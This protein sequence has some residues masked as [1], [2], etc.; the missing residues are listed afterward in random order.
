MKL[1]TYKEYLKM[2]KE[3]IEETLAPIRALQARK[4]AE[5][6]MAKLDE[7]IITLE[8]EITSLCTQN[9]I[10]FDRIINKQDEMKLAER[11]RK[12]FK[13]IIDQLSVK[14]KQKEVSDEN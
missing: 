7:K 9:R 5:L 12:P 1:R 3:K 2:T 14:I 6:E 11:R 4:Q 10:L 8:S 13:E